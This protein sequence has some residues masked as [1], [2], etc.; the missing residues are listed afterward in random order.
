M[1]IDNVLSFTFRDRTFKIFSDPASEQMCQQYICRGE[2]WEPWLTEY[3]LNNLQPNTV[4]VDAGA[5]VGWF[6]LLAAAHCPHGRIIAFEPNS[7][8]HGMLAHSA[9]VN[10]FTNVTA[11]R[12]ALSDEDGITTIGGRKEDQMGSP[13]QEIRTVRL[14]ETLELL[15]VDQVDLVKMDIEGAEVR[16]LH[17]MEQTLRAPNIKVSIETHPGLMARYGDAAE[18]LYVLMDRHGFKR[19]SLEA[20]PLHSRRFDISLYTIFEKHIGD[21]DA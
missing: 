20:E 7:R 16:A 19:L 21:T 14:D 9:A 1:S 5:S 3:I 17:G 15:G 6:T 12:V 11:L 10:G 4:V 13:G 8:R 18:D 2:T